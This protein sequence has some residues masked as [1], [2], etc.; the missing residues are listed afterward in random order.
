MSLGYYLTADVVFTE[1]ELLKAIEDSG[2]SVDHQAIEKLERGIKITEFIETIGVIFSLIEA[3]T[4]TFPFGHFESPFIEGG[5]MRLSYIYFYIDK[6]K[7]Y[8]QA[9]VIEEFIMTIVFKLTERV[10]CFAVLDT[11]DSYQLCLITPTE[12]IIDNTEGAW[13][14]P[15]LKPSLQGL[16]YREFDGIPLKYPEA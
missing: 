13:D 11:S 12:V 5:I 16:N 4:N 7:Y 14:H 8:E 9:P 2:Y 1:E 15:Y 6:Q 3:R 10:K